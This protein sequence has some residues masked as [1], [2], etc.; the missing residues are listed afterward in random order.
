MG[1]R[2]KSRSP[3]VEGIRRRRG[4]RL[5]IFLISREVII[6]YLAEIL[7]LQAEGGASKSAKDDGG[8]PVVRQ[9]RCKG[10]GRRSREKREEVAE[11]SQDQREDRRYYVVPS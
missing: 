6:G 7:I 1:E 2:T 10:E 3:R 11:L 4:R 9:V 8:W 5:R